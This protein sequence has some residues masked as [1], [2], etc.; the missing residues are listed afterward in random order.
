MNRVVSLLLV[1]NSSDPFQTL[2]G[3]LKLYTDFPKYGQSDFHLFTNQ[4]HN[5]EF[6]YS[7]L[8]LQKLR[9]PIF[10]IFHDFIDLSA[11]KKY[12]KQ[13]NVILS[14]NKRSFGLKIPRQFEELPFHIHTCFESLVRQ[15]HESKSEFRVFHVQNCVFEMYMNFLF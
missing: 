2:H 4:I 11:G 6:L 5:S 12:R 13:N 9:I 1:R 7:L 8:F 14:M 3:I 15:A 10:C